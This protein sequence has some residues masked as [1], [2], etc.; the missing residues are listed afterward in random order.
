MIHWK[1]C[2]TFVEIEFLV[3][4]RLLVKHEALGKNSTF[5]H[6]EIFL[7]KT[8]SNV[9]FFLRTI[10]LD[11]LYLLFSLCMNGGLDGVYWIDDNGK[12]IQNKWQKK[13]IKNMRTIK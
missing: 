8:I 5:H 12:N 7:E 1:T 3:N 2:K 11:L 10:G 4:L 9:K 6:V 13:G